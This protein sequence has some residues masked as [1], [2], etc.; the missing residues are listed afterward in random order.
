MKGYNNE[1]GYKLLKK[2]DTCIV[3]DESRKIGW[4]SKEMPKTVG[5]KV[6]VNRVYKEDCSAS[7]NVKKT[8]E[9]WWYY[10]E[11]LRLFNRNIE[12]KRVTEL[13][14]SLID[15]IKKIESR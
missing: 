4:N 6:L 15:K 5:E 7:C 9:H 14:K 11:D 3:V 8:G 13:V 2:N 12:K 1:Y 10:T